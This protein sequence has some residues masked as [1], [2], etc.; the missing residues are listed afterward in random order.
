MECTPM[1][2]A[3]I[4]HSLRL[5]PQIQLASIPLSIFAFLPIHTEKCQ[6]FRLFERGN[7]FLGHRRQIH[8][9]PRQFLDFQK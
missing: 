5:N 2:L 7:T 4:A 8:L 9:D 3:Y 1:V 6:L